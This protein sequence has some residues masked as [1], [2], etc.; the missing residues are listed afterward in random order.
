L[1]RD[2]DCL[3]Y[4]TTAGTNAVIEHKGTPV[5]VLVEAGEE[6]ALYGAKDALNDNQLWQAMVPYRPAGITVTSGGGIDG[7]ELTKIVNA[8]LS[9]GALR[10][11]VALRSKEAEQNVKAEL[12]ERYPRHLL[13]AIP[14]LVSFEL[15]EDADDARRTVTAVVNSYLHP[16]MEHFLYG[17]ETICK[18][19]HLHRPL[20][21]YRNDGDSARVAKTTAIKTWGSGPRGGLEGAV[22][23]ARLYGDASVLAMD[24][25]GT[26]TDLSLVL[27][28]AVQMR[29]YGA[30]GDVRTSLALPD[31]H[32]FGLGGSSVVTVEGGTFRIGPESVGASPGPA[33]FA[34]GGTDA[35][36]TD[37]LLVCGVIDANAYLGGEMKLDVARAEQAL[38]SAIGEPLGMDA[39]AAALATV[40]AFEKASGENLA[41]AVRNA[42]REPGETCLVAYGGGG[43]MIVTGIAEAAGIT[44]III[45]RLA[46]V[47]SAFGIGFSHLAHAYQ[48]RLDGA[49]PKTVEAE[50][51]ARAERDMYGE[52]VAPEDCRYESGLWGAKG[53]NVIEAPLSEAEEFSANVDDARVS[54]KAT[55][56]LPASTLVG[57]DGKSGKAAQVSGST[58]VLLGGETA[59]EVRTYDDADLRSGQTIEGPGLI[60]G[61]YLTCLIGAG[62]GLRVT[63]NLDLVIEADR[64]D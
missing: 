30:V 20:L 2:T 33:C 5:A 29:P 11:I 17:A 4:S 28:K 16:G 43:P 59:T 41:A 36:L 13:G 35:T 62:W 57:D 53:E 6:D 8:L 47:F 60:R 37:A 22:A 1:I 40:R 3:R 58:D 63:S 9:E 21:I 61:A 12:L 49:A 26:T 46:S 10:L 25:G 39:A 14:F 18:D 24:I 7:E 34:R 23:Y 15:V 51:R 52:G 19:H 38:L 45:P 50:L 32:S 44:R 42:G 64:H 27:D 31:L 48:A 55:F 56:E 54:V